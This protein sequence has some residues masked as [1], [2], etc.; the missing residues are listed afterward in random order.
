MLLFQHSRR[1]RV[2]IVVFMHW[3]DLLKDDGTTV[4]FSGDEM[5]GD[6][7]ELHAVLPRLILGVDAGECGKQRW[8]N[9]ENGVRESTDE[10]RAQEA[11]EASQTHKRDLSRFQ[12]TDQ[13]VVEILTRRERLLVGV[14][15]HEGLDS[16]VFGALE[17][18]R[19]M[20]V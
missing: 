5:N 3:H 8:M 13:L 2:G 9:V 4:E 7:R 19:I 10:H 20:R 11:H 15:E 14:V 1:K 6:S 18:G 16:C 17:S 12:L